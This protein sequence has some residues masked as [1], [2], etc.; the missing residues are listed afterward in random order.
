MGRQR[1]MDPD[2]RTGLLVVLTI[3][4]AGLARPAGAETWREQSRRSVPGA[5]LTALTVQNARGRVEARPSRDGDL[6]ITALKIARGRQESQAREIARDA[7]VELERSGGRYLVRVRY[8]RQQSVHVNLWEPFDLSVRRLE[9][10]ITVEVP[11]DLACELVTS[12]GDLF[13]EDLAGPQTLR[14]SS[15]D[16]SV[17]GAKAGIEVSTSSGDVSLTDGRAARI[18]T[19]SGDVEVAG[20]MDALSVST[21][22]GD[23]EVGEVADTVRIETAS[24]DVTVDRTA[25]GGLVRTSSGEVRVHA[26]GGRLGVSTISGEVRVR[27]VAPLRALAVTTSSGDVRIGLDPA[28]GCTLEMRT[29]SGSFDLDVSARS[30][31]MSRRAITATVGDGS[32]PVSLKTTSG[33]IA[34]VSGEP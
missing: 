11:R 34:V 28:V 14:S 15:G 9:V 13:T 30:Q 8:P 33:S 5:G 29:S 21:S 3:L 7:T 18:G 6:H 1:P 27:A 10:R 22:S 20:R 4:G 19:S 23:V 31:T 26:A 17:A 16:V 2:M 12:S 32:A 24:G 25:R